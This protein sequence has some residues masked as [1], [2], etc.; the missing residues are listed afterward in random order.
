MRN[1]GFDILRAVAVGLVFCRH[2]GVPLA[3]RFGWVGVDLFFVLSGFLVAGLLFREYRETGCI[4]PWRFLLRRGCKIYPQF[5]FFIFVTVV[6]RAL[7]GEPISHRALAAE[8]GF[9]QN[10]VVGLWGHT[11]SLA[12]EEHFYVLLAIALT[13]SARSGGAN[14]FRDL[15]QWITATCALILALRITAWLTCS[16]VGGS[17]P[18]F[19]H[20]APSHLRMDSL[21][22]GV[23]LSYL[24]CFRAGELA[25]FARRFGDWFPV[26]SAALLAPAGLLEQSS[27]FI[28]TLG[29]SM[30]AMAFSLVLLGVLY[31]KDP[32]GHGVFPR[33]L[34]RLGRV[35][36]A[37]YL[38]H[39]PMLFLAD[40]LRLPAVAGIPLA[41]AGTLG[42]A[43]ASTRLIEDPCLR[44]R[45][46]FAR[47][48]CQS[49][50]I[51]KAEAPC[52][53]Q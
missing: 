26:A 2:S 15:P 21:L 19:G 1:R 20:I 28:Y 36:Y 12:V 23:L 45:E 9:F 30:T 39:G 41:F 47:E 18:L 27:P 7:I 32:I 35:S 34:A 53:A 44:W 3:G 8:L 52:A 11:W 29:F 37:F 42:L 31:P 43:F 51:G 17:D 48:R 13:L 5:Y 24:H 4:N 22:M 25:G 16:R 46:T 49:N 6:G 10:Y 33:S 38:W 50:S 40:R 14:P